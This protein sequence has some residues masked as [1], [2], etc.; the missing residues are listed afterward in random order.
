MATVIK[1]FDE[2]FPIFPL[3]LLQAVAL[4]G[5]VAVLFLFQDRNKST[6]SQSLAL[7]FTLGISSIFLTGLMVEWL[8]NSARVLF[9]T[10]F[11]FLAGLLGGWRNALLAASLSLFGRLFFGGAHNVL[12]A[13]VD[14]CFIVIGSCMLR[15]YFVK[16]NKNIISLGSGLTIVFWRFV[17][18]ESSLVFFYAIDPSMRELAIG[19]MTRRSV[20]AF[21]FSILIVF[22]V[23]LLLRREQARERQL[24]M[25]ALSQ[26]PNRRALQKDIEK[27]YALDKK[28]PGSLLLIDI[29]NF[30]ELVLELGHD[31]VDNL[32]QYMGKALSN[33]TRE[34]W[35]ASYAPSIYC[36]SD[37]A[38]ILTLQQ[39]SMR[40]V[41]EKGLAPKVYNAILQDMQGRVLSL[42]PRLAMGVFD[43]LPEHAHNSSRFLRTLTLVERSSEETVRY[44]EPRVMDQI[45][46]EAQ[47]RQYIEEWVFTNRVPLYLQPKV[48]LKDGR[49][50]G[51]EALLRAW[52]D[53][54]KTRYISPPEIF[55]IAE[56]HHMLKALEWATVETIISYLGQLPLELE[57]LTL[58]IN[59]SPVSLSHPGLGERIAAL[60]AEKNIKGERLVVELIETSRLHTANKAVSDNVAALAASGVKLSLDDFGT[61]YSSISLLSDLPFD[62][63]KLDYSMISN[64][65]TQRGCAAV[66]LSIEGAKRYSASIV[67]EGVETPQQQ[68]QLLDLGVER[69]QGFLFSKAIELKSFI[70]YAGHSLLEEASVASLNKIEQV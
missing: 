32:F 47:I 23:I 51:G 69:A 70:Q 58:S 7:G 65:G 40:E 36:F 64:M 41:E 22:S 53:I 18:V 68:Q 4:I 48:L 19:A 52:G 16:H 56:T 15:Y 9:L 46:H 54:Q 45:Q 66:T 20:G 34:S 25:E 26:L 30:R 5:I 60:L 31:W 21:S 28:K 38:F 27:T 3:M 50:V 43:L 67:A 61:G 6:R 42:R 11:I 39:I 14:T 37:R 44:F 49:C 63:L 29:S 17:I 33:L 10:D 12:F 2:F 13:I 24:Y 57:A 35:I 55:S 8:D 62:E 59:L 1:A